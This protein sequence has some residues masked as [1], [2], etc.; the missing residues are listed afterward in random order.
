[1]NMATVD[2]PETLSN[3]KDTP[4]HVLDE[5][6]GD[7]YF[8]PCTSLQLLCPE[9]CRDADHDLFER[10]TLIDELTATKN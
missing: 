10:C 4:I 3:L 1:M 8:G 5:E 6:I 7:I 2:I 9:S